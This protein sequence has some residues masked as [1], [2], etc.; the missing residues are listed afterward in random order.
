MELTNTVVSR[1]WNPRPSRTRLLGICG[2][3]GAGK[4][5]LASALSLELRARGVPNC[6]YSGDW[7]FRLDSDAR[8]QWLKES[9]REGGF[10]YFC[11]VNQFNW[12][13]FGQIFSD[14]E[15]LAQ[16]RE[17]CLPEVYDRSSGVRGDFL[18]LRLE[19]PGII[20]YENAVLGG[21]ELLEGLDLIVTVN[22]PDALCL[23]RTL[24][25]DVARRSVPEIAAR[26][27]I[28]TYS[29]N[30][31]LRG[32][33]SFRDRVVACTDA[34]QLCGF[35]DVTRESQLPVSAQ[36]VLGDTSKAVL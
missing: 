2:R 27:L 26:Y 16:G 24:R 25:R 9:E 36:A 5:S 18:S 32:L 30:I 35:P 13:D 12:W 8:K 4:T 6:V 15:A 23:E 14:L 29:E 28:T 1:L 21:A 22:T 17:I 20:V 10:P 31:F 19:G 11:A 3:A 33:S 34:G 7:R